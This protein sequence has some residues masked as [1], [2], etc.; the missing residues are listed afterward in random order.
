MGNTY[1]RNSAVLDP[2]N[3]MQRTRG[4]QLNIVTVSDEQKIM[5]IGQTL[6]DQIKK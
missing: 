5:D 4:N 2:V 6:V 1:V 3:R